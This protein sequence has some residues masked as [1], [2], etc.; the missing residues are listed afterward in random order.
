ML[1]FIGIA[2]VI[3]AICLLSI[4]IYL[5]SR[6]HKA[7]QLAQEYLG[8]KYEQEMRYESVRYSWIDPGQY[9]VYFISADTEIWFEVSMWP[10]ALGFSDMPPDEYM[11]DNY[12]IC[13]FHEN[14]EEIILPE[15]IN[16]WDE[17]INIRVASSG[18]KGYPSRGTEEPNEQ[19]TILELECLYNYEV[20]INTNRILTDDTKTE[21]AKRIFE[22]IQ[23]IKTIQFQPREVL[24]LYQTGETENG[25]DVECRIWFGDGSDPY[26]IGRFENWMETSS[27]EEIEKIM[28]DQWFNKQIVH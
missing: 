7:I 17:N 22:M 9:H 18:G 23:Y 15:A 1:K 27:I 2:I 16:I 25:K 13:F 14:L 11:W 20:Y 6:E 8:Q 3:I 12:L 26:H 24:F 28:N 5:S 21:E 4:K 10:K 19:M